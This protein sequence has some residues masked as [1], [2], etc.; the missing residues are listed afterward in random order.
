MK[1]LCAVSASF[2]DV[3]ISLET[4]KIEWKSMYVWENN[5]E[6]NLPVGPK[7]RLLM[8]VM[9]LAKK[10]LNRSPGLSG[11]YIVSGEIKDGLEEV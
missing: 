11:D 4:E 9:E 7:V 6:L 2:L 1:L 5:L 10:W 8:I 3:S